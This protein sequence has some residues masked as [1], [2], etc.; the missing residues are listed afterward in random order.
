VIIMIPP[1]FLFDELVENFCEAVTGEGG[2]LEGEVHS[3][4]SVFGGFKCV[5][6]DAR[7]DKILGENCPFICPMVR[8]E[9]VELGLEF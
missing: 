1:K 2:L 9:V 5:L 7:V 6:L 4:L 8:I 3:L